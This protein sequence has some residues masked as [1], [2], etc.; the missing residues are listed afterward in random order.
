MTEINPRIGK[1]TKSFLMMYPLLKEKTIPREVKVAIHNTLL[2]PT[3]LYGSECWALASK[4]RSN[5]QAAEMTALRVIKVVN[6]MDKFGNERIRADLEV[7]RLLDFVE[8]G[9]LRWY[10][11][12]MRM[13]DG[14]IPRIYLPWKPQ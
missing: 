7:K 14:R 1:D 3:L 2:R 10:G 8:E 13:R 12:V 9:R 4:T 6:R 11:H 5:L